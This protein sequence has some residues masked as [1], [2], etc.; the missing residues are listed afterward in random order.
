[1][2]FPIFAKVVV[3]QPFDS[4]HIHH[5]EVAKL[6]C[7]FCHR[8]VE[9]NRVAGIPNIELCQAC[10]STDAISKRP[11]ALKVVGYVKNHKPIPWKRMY[12]LPP[13]GRFSSLDPYSKRCRLLD[14]SRGYRR[15]GQ[16]HE[17]GGSTLYGVVPEM[18]S[19]DGSFYR[20]LHVPFELVQA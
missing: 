20:L 11:E 17:N 3:D 19:E 6:N 14:L 9:R 8:Y 10:H 2:E 1:M 12:Q 16:T 18:P 7:T 5:K 13:F 15:D 4:I